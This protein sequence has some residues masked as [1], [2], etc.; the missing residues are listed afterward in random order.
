MFLFRVRLSYEKT[1]KNAE[2]KKQFS[3]NSVSSSSGVQK[4]IN[5]DN[6]NWRAINQKSIDIKSFKLP[7]NLIREEKNSIVYSVTF[8]RDNIHHRECSNLK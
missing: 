6:P 1:S 8:Q 5:H 7:C 4:S 3:A 2:K